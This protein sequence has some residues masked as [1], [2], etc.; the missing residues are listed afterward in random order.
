MEYNTQ[1]NKLIISEYGRNVQKM[2]EHC[3]SIEDREQRSK[4]AKLIVSVM[5][6]MNPKSRE[7]GDYKQKLWDH[8]YIIS[9]F[10]MDVDSNYPPP[11]KDL[12]NAKP[13]PIAYS[14]NKIKYRHYGKNTEKIIEKA[15]TYEEGAEKDA[16]I[17]TIANHMKKS[18]LN[19]NRNSVNDELI[20]LHLEELSD[21]KLQMNKDDRLSH[22]NEILA[23][24]KKRKIVKPTNNGKRPRK[25]QE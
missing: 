16:L 23:R 22:T 11:S 15:I 20:L 9:D 17:K 18:Y 19:W 4:T 25:R 14:E 13:E 8:M 6:Q 7:A 12:L 10:K 21:S 3:V 5:G 24:N 1:R 2:I